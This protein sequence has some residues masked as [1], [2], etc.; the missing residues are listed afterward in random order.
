M[1]IF[2]IE[3]T[4]DGAIDWIKSA[5][6]QDNYRVVKMILESCQMLSSALNIL[7]DSN[8]APYKT[9]HA[10]HPSS[11]WVRESSANFE[12]LIEHTMALL[13][14]Y[15]SRFQKVHKCKAVL[16]KIIEI[17][18]CNQDL[19]PSSEETSLPLCM[20]EEFKG[21]STVESYRSFY[22]SKPRIRYPKD[23]I[24]PWF[25]KYRGDIPFQVIQPRVKL[26]Q[27]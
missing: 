22:S 16:D 4:S 18:S 5:Q 3:E 11:K 24:P 13:D 8:I 27:K 25:K 21:P 20:P 9:T 10:N 23:K 7:S 12:C 19:F 15:T 1:N 17:Y 26:C 2:A 14:E 6:S